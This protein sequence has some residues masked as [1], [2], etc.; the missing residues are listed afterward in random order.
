MSIL[1]NNVLVSLKWSGLKELFWLLIE[2]FN[3]FFRKTDFETKSHSFSNIISYCL[4]EPHAGSSELRTIGVRCSNSPSSK[5]LK[6]WRT[7]WT[8]NSS[9]SWFLA[10]RQGRFDD[11]LRPVRFQGLIYRYF[12]RLQFSEFFENLVSQ[13]CIRD[14]RR[15]CDVLI[16]Q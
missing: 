16:P 7:A 11:S 1:K 15:D 5:K 14:I 8:A 13:S 3:F 6:I 10:N 12:V 2:Q 9:N 4:T